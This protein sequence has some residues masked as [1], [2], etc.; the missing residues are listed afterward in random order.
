MKYLAVLALAV[1]GCDSQSGRVEIDTSPPVIEQRVQDPGSSLADLQR[2]FLDSFSD[3]SGDVSGFILAETTIRDHE[4]PP[5][6][7]TMIPPT[8]LNSDYLRIVSKQ[9]PHG[10]VTATDL[11]VLQRADSAYVVF[12][13]SEHG[14]PSATEW[15]WRHGRWSVWAIELNVPVAVIA[16]A[17]RRSL[18]L[19]RTR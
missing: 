5:S 17:R 2:E 3:P 16:E 7:Q 15:I 19:A 9:L 11:E 8:S 12:T 18:R 1:V 10:F 14:P 13:F 6:R 4:D